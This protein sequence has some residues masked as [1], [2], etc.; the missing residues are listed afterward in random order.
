[1]DLTIVNPRLSKFGHQGRI[2]QH[3]CSHVEGGR[4]VGGGVSTDLPGEALKQGLR[5]RFRQESNSS[6]KLK[7]ELETFFLRPQTLE[8]F[9]LS[10]TA[11]E[12]EI[13]IRSG[14]SIRRLKK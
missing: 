11:V 7:I 1:M 8:I 6:K 4:V 13:K 2:S 12:Q 14:R 5:S 3:V 10:K 9:I